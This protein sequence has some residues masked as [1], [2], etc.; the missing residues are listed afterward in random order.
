MGKK[1]KTKGKVGEREA[2]AKLSHLLGTKVERSQQYKGG[3]H[4]ADLSGAGRLHPEVKRTERL[5]LYDAMSQAA[6]DAGANNL[7]IVIH[8]RNRQPWLFIC[9]LDDLTNV[10]QEVTRIR[11][12]HT[13]DK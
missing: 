2:A 1:S 10:A 7:P 9:Y 8:R 11:K 4:S 13:G 3:Q 6:N 5:N 12:G